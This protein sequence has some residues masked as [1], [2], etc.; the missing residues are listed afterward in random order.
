MK[1]KENFMYVSVSE[2]NNCC[3]VLHETLK[4]AENGCISQIRGGSEKEVIYKAIKRY[5]QAEPIMEKI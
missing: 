5:K 4:G 2:D 3:M 1:R